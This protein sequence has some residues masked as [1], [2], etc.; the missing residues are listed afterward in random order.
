MGS[1][2]KENLMWISLINPDPQSTLTLAKGGSKRLG[3]EWAGRPNTI[4]HGQFQII[5]TLRRLSGCLAQGSL[6]IELQL[7]FLAEVGIFRFSGAWPAGVTTNSYSRTVDLH[8]VRWRVRRDLNLVGHCCGSR[9]SGLPQAV[10]SFGSS[11][12]MP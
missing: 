9:P 3:R 1:Q 7:R 10:K 5:L 12:H 6:S 2:G 11:K 4:S 8:S